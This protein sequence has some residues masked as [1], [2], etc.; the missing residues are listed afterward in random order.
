MAAG[1]IGLRLA[2][3]GDSCPIINSPFVHFTAPRAARRA[4]AKEGERASSAAGLQPAIEIHVD[5]AN[6]ASAEYVACVDDESQCR[7]ADGEAECGDGK[8]RRRVG[9][10]ELRIIDVVDAPVVP[11][12]VHENAAVEL[13]THAASRADAGGSL[14]AQLLLEQ[15]DRFFGATEASRERVGRGAGGITLCLLR[16]GGCGRRSRSEACADDERDA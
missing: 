15:R 13:E 6:E 14:F 8:D 7:L 11:E 1:L 5:V 12:C 10:N 4:N 3:S 2:I 9:T 16:G